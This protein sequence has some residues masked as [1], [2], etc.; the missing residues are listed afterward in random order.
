MKKNHFDV[1]VLG[2]GTMGA[3]ACYYLSK[4]GLK[5]L[6]IEQFSIPHEKGSYTGQSRIIRQSYF[7]HPDYV[8][9]LR[10]AYE[11]WY[12]LES[13]VGEKVFYKTG[14]LY[15]GNAH[16]R[17]LQGC[18]D[19]A[20][21]HHLPLQTI[22]FQDIKKI[23]PQFSIPDD[24]YG[25][26]E[27]EA[28]FLCPEKI[29]SLYLELAQKEGAKVRV[30]EKV[31]KW[32]LEGESVRVETEKAAYF[33]SQLILCAG[34]WS[35]TFVS[36][37]GLQLKVTR[38]LVGWVENDHSKAFALG[39]FPCWMIDDPEKGIY[40]GFPELNDAFAAPSGMKV[41]FHSPGPLTEPDDLNRLDTSSDDEDFRFVL[42]KYLP[43]ANRKTKALKSCMYTYSPDENFVIDFHPLSQGKVVF[44]CGFSGHGFK[45][46]S[47]IG[48]ILADLVTKRKSS[49]PI[50]FLSLQRFTQNK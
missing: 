46:A 1:I 43:S 4:R 16:S 8:P 32:S 17:V 26:F 27:S 12:E 31:L 38:Q 24:F 20:Q 19:S 5:V 37:T 14:L 49:L 40:Y 42:E 23:Y 33:S 28:G 45:F 9:L 25:V 21:L 15:L 44:A 3:P 35:S 18:K 34:A 7:E 22:G 2:V 48:E 30:N 39:Y 36:E 47:V 29:V 10:R 11:N 13:I 6:G 41:A 50:G